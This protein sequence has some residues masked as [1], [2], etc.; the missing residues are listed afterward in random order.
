MELRPARYRYCSDLWCLEN[1]SERYKT[2]KCD[3]QKIEQHVSL[4]QIIDGDVKSHKTT[5]PAKYEQ[6][7]N[8]IWYRWF[9]QTRSQGIPSLSCPI[10]MAKAIAMNNKVNGDPN[11]KASIDC[12]ISLNFDN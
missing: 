7:D 12:L 6:L 1:N 10:I 8:V 4:M 5:M 3:A 9:M 2:I 11:F